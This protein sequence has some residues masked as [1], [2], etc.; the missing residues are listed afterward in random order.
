MVSPVRNL[1]ADD[2]MGVIGSHRGEIRG[3]GVRRLGLFGSFLKGG[4]RKRSDLDFLVTFDRPTFDNYMGLKFLLERLFHRK[5]DLVVED[6]LKPALKYVRDEA[7]Y[8][9]GL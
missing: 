3:F 8:A 2:V 7:V 1:S 9:E 5:V 6:N 4:K